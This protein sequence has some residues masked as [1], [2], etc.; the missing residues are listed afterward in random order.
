MHVKESFIGIT[1]K[2]ITLSLCLIPFIY[3][4]TIKKFKEN[5]FKGVCF[6][7]KNRNQRGPISQSIAD[8]TDSIFKVKKT[9]V[10]W[11]KNA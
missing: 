2:F 11:I 10:L 9:Q 8:R 5:T 3:L 4:R 1:S 7:Y 6:D